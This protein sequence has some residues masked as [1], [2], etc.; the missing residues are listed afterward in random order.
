MDKRSLDLKIVGEEVAERMRSYL[1]RNSARVEEPL[2]LANVDVSRYDAVVVPGGHGPVE[3]LYEDPDMG[4]V[5]VQADREAKIIAAICHGGAAGSQGQAWRM[6]F[7]RAQDDFPHR[8]RGDRVRG[9]G[10]CALAA[11]RHAAQVRRGL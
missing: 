2:I 10:Q 6:A 8:R 7:H 9:G 3:D 11:R 1:V 4:R 5:L